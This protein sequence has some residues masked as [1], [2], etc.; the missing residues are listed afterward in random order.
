[1]IWYKPRPPANPYLW[2]MLTTS[3][4]KKGEYFNLDS[5]HEELFSLQ[6]SY[7]TRHDPIERRVKPWSNSL[8][9]VDDAKESF[10]KRLKE[11]EPGDED[12]RGAVAIYA[13]GQIRLGD[14]RCTACQAAS[15]T[16]EYLGFPLQMT[17]PIPFCTTTGKFAHGICACCYA[18]GGSL[19][20]RLA[21]CSV[22]RA[23][24]FE[25]YRELHDP[26]TDAGSGPG[27]FIGGDLEERDVVERLLF[28]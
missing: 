20:E 22:S 9:F 26:A 8:P 15:S 19:P 23:V 25:E 6:S 10:Y 5:E 2:A 24:S 4:F 28:S 13:A 27:M 17:A 11:D 21:R 16:Y 3:P 7:H 12:I 18:A 1:F 14:A